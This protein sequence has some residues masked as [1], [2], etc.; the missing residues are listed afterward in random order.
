MLPLRLI[1]AVLL[2]LIVAACGGAAPTTAPSIDPDAPFIAAANLEFDRD[3]L[4]V[5]AGEAFKLVFENREAAPHNVAIYADS[6]VSTE[7]FKGEVFS[8]PAT[9]TYDVPAL[10]AGSYYFRCDLHPN[11]DGSVTAQ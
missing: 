2:L 4:T 3:L 5:P 7:L 10:A 11:M 1:P 6:S 8:G 9:R